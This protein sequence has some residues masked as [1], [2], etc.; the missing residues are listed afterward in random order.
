MGLYICRLFAPG[1]K[2]II[3]IP[4]KQFCF[5]IWTPHQALLSWKWP[6]SR[7]LGT[8]RPC[9][10]QEQTVT[11]GWRYS[12]RDNQESGSSDRHPKS[13]RPFFF[14]SSH[15]EMMKL[16]DKKFF[17]KVPFFLHIKCLTDKKKKCLKCPRIIFAILTSTDQERKLYQGQKNI[18][19]K[20][21]KTS[22]HKNLYVNVHSST[23][24]HSQKAV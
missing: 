20:E 15:F 22:S 13:S 19:P 21:M 3:G 6:S 8:S 16:S 5:C 17:M 9:L 12:W 23:I 10:C 24:Y 4:K 1:Y 11:G 14:I 18:H 7:V 2:P